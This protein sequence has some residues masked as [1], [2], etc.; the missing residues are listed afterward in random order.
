MEG[1]LHEE[2]GPKAFEGK[3]KEWMDK[4]VDRL[5]KRRNGIVEKGEGKCPA[6]AF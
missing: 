4:E 2:V 1:Y 3:G 6:V 5:M